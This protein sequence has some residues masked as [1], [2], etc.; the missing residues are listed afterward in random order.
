MIEGVDTGTGLSVLVI[1][2]L[3][4][5]RAIIPIAQAWARKI[6]NKKNGGGK[7][8]GQKQNGYYKN[9]P[10]SVKENILTEM[11]Y[12]SNPNPPGETK[13]CRENRDKIIGLEKD[14]QNM[15]D[16]IQEIKRDIAKIRNGR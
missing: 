14:V 13:V 11:G 2:Y 9:L 1:I 15:K 4:T 8:Q 6:N 3:L 16:D 10:R 5:E 12:A 7:A